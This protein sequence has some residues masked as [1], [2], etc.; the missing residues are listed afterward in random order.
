MLDRLQKKVKEIPGGHPTGTSL[1]SAHNSVFESYGLKNNQNAPTCAECAEK[2][3]E[4]LNHLLSNPDAHIGFP[5]TKLILWSGEK[6][7][8]DW[9]RV[10]T[11]PEE[12]DVR[13][14][15]GDRRAADS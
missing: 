12:S 6:P 4:S 1:I 9:V 15:A 8:K 5:S 11:S 14:L 2:F 10:L 7:Q 3:T 13:E